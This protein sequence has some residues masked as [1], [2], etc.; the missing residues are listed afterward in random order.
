MRLGWKRAADLE[1]VPGGRWR[2]WIG[3]WR[4]LG[5]R[6]RQCPIGKIG[7]EVWCRCVTFWI[8]GLEMG[9]EGVRNEEICLSS[10]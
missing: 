8:F 3:R 6:S 7:G 4:G 9:S 2:S 5:S 10:I 1:D